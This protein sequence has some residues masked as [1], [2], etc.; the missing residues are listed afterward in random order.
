MTLVHRPY[1]AD[2][3]YTNAHHHNVG[4]QCLKTADLAGT[5]LGKL[6]RNTDA[7]L[8]ENLGGM[9][10]LTELGGLKRYADIDTSASFAKKTLI[11][12]IEKMSKK[13]RRR[14]EERAAAYVHDLPPV[15]PLWLGE[16]RRAPNAP[17]QSGSVPQKKLPAGAFRYTP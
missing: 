10:A 4:G 8:A 16:D 13:E 2:R 17:V 7:Q 15:Q 1:R 11:G 5:K 3:C 9:E 14:Y 12:K 6:D